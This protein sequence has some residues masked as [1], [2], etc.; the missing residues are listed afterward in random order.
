LLTFIPATGDYI[1]SELLGSTQDRMIGNVIQT[2]FIEFRDYPTASALS[3]AL[4]AAI[5]VLV[6]TYIRRAG[7]EDLL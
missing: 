3:F 7:T 5:L 6:F 4:M 1:N 2:N